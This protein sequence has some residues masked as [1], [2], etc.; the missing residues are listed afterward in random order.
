MVKTHVRPKLKIPRS[1]SEWVWDMIGFSCY[2]GSIVLL[3]FVWN[4]LPAEVPAHY[5]ALG[6]VDRWGSKWELII[7]PGIGAFIILLM[8][9][10]EK[11]PEIHNY[12]E[13]L[14]ESNAVQFYLLSR[15][16]VNQLKNISL[17]IFAAIVFELVSIALGWGNGFVAWFLP[18]AIATVFIPIIIGLMKQ[19]KIQ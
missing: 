14:N 5:N 16:L 4:S 8:Q 9:M 6:E 2:I 10:F 1:K 13:R 3:I 15:K 17:I 18:V 19:R 11:Y 12:P 7:L